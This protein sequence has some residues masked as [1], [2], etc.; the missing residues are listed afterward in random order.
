[1]T[2]KRDNGYELHRRMLDSRGMKFL[3]RM[4]VRSFSLNIL[5]MDAR[6]LRDGAALLE[7]TDL[8]I[9]LMMEKNR[10]AGDQAHREI[11][12]LLHNFLAAAKTLVDHTRVFMEEHYPGSA[13]K[14]R[15]AEKVETD[16]ADNEVCKFVHDLRNYMLHRGLP[17]ILRYLTFDSGKGASCGVQLKSAD[18]L[19]WDKW[20]AAGRRYLQKNETIGL[21]Q[22]AHDYAERVTA[23]HKW[24]DDELREHHRQDL[25]EF[26]AMQQEHRT[27]YPEV[28]ERLA[29]EMG[30]EESTQKS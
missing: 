13:L 28:H 18:L 1:M 25:D 12:R 29:A 16:L 26:F 23:F 14:R 5:I 27:K 21:G 19:T 3:D 24:L 10:A 30:Q 6:E 11:G 20:T 8:A 7:N 17:N 2:E 9:P 4:R 15:Y 22:I